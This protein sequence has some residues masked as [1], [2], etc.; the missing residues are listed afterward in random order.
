M[1]LLEGPD[2]F[3]YLAARSCKLKEMDA[4]C[5]VRHNGQPWGGE[6]LGGRFGGEKVGDL[7]K[8]GFLEPRGW[9]NVDFFV[10]FPGFVGGLGWGKKRNK[11]GE[12]TVFLKHIGRYNKI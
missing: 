1:E 6:G 3:D 5:L 4:I 11:K 7:K 10:K 2:L 12:R 8:P 9:G